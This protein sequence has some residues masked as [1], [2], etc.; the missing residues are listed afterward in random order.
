V[1]ENWANGNKA[2]KLLECVVEIFVGPERSKVEDV[3]QAMAH[4]KLVLVIHSLTECEVRVLH[5]RFVHWLTVMPSDRM[6]VD[7]DGRE[8]EST[9]TV[10]DRLSK[11]FLH[12]R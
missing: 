3:P 8:Q 9:N 6:N 2:E 11:L 12:Y 1:A 4:S 7:K 5:G 10:W